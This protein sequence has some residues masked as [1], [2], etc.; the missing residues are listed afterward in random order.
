MQMCARTIKVVKITVVSVN[1]VFVWYSSSDF[2]TGA[3]L[4]LVGTAA[5]TASVEKPLYELLVLKRSVAIGIGQ[6]EQA[7]DLLRGQA[8]P[9]ARHALERQQ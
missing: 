6:L 8:Q 5:A 4:E 1:I 3:G 9:E 2:R 7:L